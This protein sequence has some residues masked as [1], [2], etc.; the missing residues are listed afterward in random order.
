[1]F[2][3]PVWLERLITILL[4][5]ASKMQEEVAPH[6][7]AWYFV[8]RDDQNQLKGPISRRDLDVMIK[9]NA[10]DSDSYVYKPGMTSWTQIRD[11]K[12]LC[13]QLM[14]RPSSPRGPTR[15]HATLRGVLCA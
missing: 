7:Q 4:D 1:M 13:T 14:G 11:V 3:K 10:L 15:S 2:E 8:D 6:H 5:F 9:T 12:E